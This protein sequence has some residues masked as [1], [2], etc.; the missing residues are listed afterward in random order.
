VLRS[1]YAHISAGDRLVS[2]LNHEEA[3]AA[4]LPTVYEVN[5]ADAKILRLAPSVSED[6]LSGRGSR[7]HP[8]GILLSRIVRRWYRHRAFSRILQE[9][10]SCYHRIALSRNMQLG[11]HGLVFDW[12]Q[13]SLPSVIFPRSCSENLACILSIQALGKVRPYL[14]LSDHELFLQAW[15]QAAKYYG[16]N[17]DKESHKEQLDQS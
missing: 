3:L 1:L 17:A 11:T 4:C 5:S 10:H 6:A 8:I 9:A 14:A 13:E 15:F 12:V 7:L 2:T 16:R